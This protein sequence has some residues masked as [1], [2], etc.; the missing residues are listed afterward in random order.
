MIPKVHNMFLMV[1]NMDSTFGLMSLAAVHPKLHL[2]TDKCTEP[3]YLCASVTWDLMVL[4][5]SKPKVDNMFLMVENMLSTFILIYLAPVYPKLH[6]H[7]DNCTEPTYLC[8][9][10]TWDLMVLMASNQRWITFF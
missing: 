4:M 1:E 3:T 8:A 5:A 6:L 2:H 10:V 9:S 7:T